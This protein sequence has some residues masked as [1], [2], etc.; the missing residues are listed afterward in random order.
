MNSKKA[1]EAI[2]WTRQLVNKNNGQLPEW[3]AYKDAVKAHH[4]DPF[5]VPFK[6]PAEY[7]YAYLRVKGLSHAD[8]AERMGLEVRPEDSGKDQ[9]AAAGKKESWWKFW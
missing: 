4:N 1:E 9:T 8:A 3:S 2:V 5:N 6:L 7:Q